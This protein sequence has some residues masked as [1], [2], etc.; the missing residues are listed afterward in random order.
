MLLWYEDTVH[1]S[2]PV[3][4]AHGAH[5]AWGS[6]RAKGPKRGEPPPPCLEKVAGRAPGS[7]PH[8]ESC[9]P[10]HKGLMYEVGS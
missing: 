7:G 8:T 4:H 3:A 10:C 1:E 2:P 9:Q 6:R 5:G